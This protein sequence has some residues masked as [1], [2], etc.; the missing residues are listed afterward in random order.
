M[1]VAVQSHFFAVGSVVPWG[2]PGAGVVATQALVNRRYGPD[3]L[4]LLQEGLEP[5]EIVKRL[6]GADEGHAY[7]QLAVLDAGGRIAAH[8]GVS[9]IKEA[10][11]QVGADY[12]AQANMMR[13]EGVPQAMGT[14]FEES[15]GPLAS[16]LSAAL[17]AAERAGGDIRGKQSAALMVM[18]T[19]YEEHFTDAVVEDIRVDDHP[20]PLQEIDRLLNLSAG[21]RELERGDDLLA[22]GKR[23][24][25]MAAYRR[26][27]EIAP[28]NQ[29]VLFWYGV[30][31]LQAGE[32]ESAHARLL[33]L[34][35]RNR[36]WWELLGRLNEAELAEIPQ[37]AIGSLAAELGYGS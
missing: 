3:A 17:H 1:G 34:C 21:Y 28:E 27:E 23:S 14:A 13:K 32:R 33:P 2:F 25:A 15:E 4:P 29:E 8:T 5:A 12:S 16:R 9:C 36:G 6:T 19:S 20:S 7:R 37:E 10:D 26:A 11:H 24:E 31:L 18:R 30:A 22:A 35:R